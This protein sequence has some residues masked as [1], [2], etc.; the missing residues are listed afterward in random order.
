MKIVYANKD[1]LAY[2][3]RVDRSSD[4]KQIQENIAKNRIYVVKENEQNVGFLHYRVEDNTP[5]IVNLIVEPAYRT[6]GY[7]KLLID[8][9]EKELDVLGFATLL[10]DPKA[11][12]KN[13]ELFEKLGYV[14]K[15]NPIFKKEEVLTKN[16]M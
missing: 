15:N 14:K 2:L 13:E 5:I 8:S 6:K 9:L 16:I 4:K 11:I 3:S 12:N 1:D 10:V 7:A